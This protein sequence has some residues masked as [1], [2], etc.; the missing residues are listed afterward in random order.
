MEFNR[1]RVSMTKINRAFIRGN[2]MCI[3]ISW[4]TREKIP[5]LGPA[6][7]AET[8]AIVILIPGEQ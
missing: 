8:S 3:S 6:V 4:V 5:C 2:Y 1:R 7:S